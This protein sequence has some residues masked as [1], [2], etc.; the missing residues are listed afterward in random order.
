MIPRMQPTM[1]NT[2][3][4]DIKAQADTTHDEH[5]QRTLDGFNIE[6]ALYG[7]QENG[8]R[9]REKKYAIKE[10]TD[11]LCSM[12]CICKTGRSVPVFLY[13]WGKEGD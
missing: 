8:E 9:Q 2:S 13:V 6:E 11:E 7:L 5:W 12:Q 3:T 10:C 4:E 1:H